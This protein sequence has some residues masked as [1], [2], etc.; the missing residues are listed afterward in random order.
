MKESYVSSI[1]L[2]TSKVSGSLLSR[3]AGPLFYYGMIGEKRFKEI[4]HKEEAQ[5][6]WGLNHES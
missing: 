4:N 1:K 3:F 2:M 6:I 5:D